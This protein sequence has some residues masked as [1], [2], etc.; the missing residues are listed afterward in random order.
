LLTPLLRGGD[1]AIRAGAR[2]G[3]VEGGGLAG[4]VGAG[5]GD[6][7]L[8]PAAGA[9]ASPRGRGSGEP[10]GAAADGAPSSAPRFRSREKILML[11]PTRPTPSAHRAR[12]LRSRSASD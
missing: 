12:D 2:L 1:G 10:G 5:G 11:R 4:M 3:S 9:A 8:R 7:W 6:I